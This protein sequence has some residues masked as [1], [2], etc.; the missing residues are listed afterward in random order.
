MYMIHVH[1]QSSSTIQLCVIHC[2]A[3]A[4]HQVVILYDVCT[5]HVHVHWY[6][7]MLACACVCVLLYM[8]GDGC[9]PLSCSIRKLCLK[10]QA[11]L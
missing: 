6:M 11:A 2:N 1:V 7:D 10:W 8:C 3:C 5:V 4:C 9:V